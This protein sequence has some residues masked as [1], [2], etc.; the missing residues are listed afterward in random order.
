MEIDEKCGH[1]EPLDD[2]TDEEVSVEAGFESI[3][4]DGARFA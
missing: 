2:S 4:I 3:C 1:W